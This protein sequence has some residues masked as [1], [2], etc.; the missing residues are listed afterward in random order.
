[1]KGPPFRVWEGSPFQFIFFFITAIDPSLALR[2]TSFV[3]RHFPY[4]VIR[5]EARMLCEKAGK[6]Q[7]DTK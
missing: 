4:P 1:M 5:T 3:S 2:M 6:R 7:Y